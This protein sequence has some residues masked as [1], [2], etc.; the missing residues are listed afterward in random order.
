M[1]KQKDVS[2]PSTNLRPR[3]DPMSQLCGNGRGIG[4]PPPAKFRSGH[5]PATAIPVSRTIPGDDSASGSENDMSTDSEEDVYGGRYSLDS[6]PQRPNGTAYRYGNPS[7]RDSQSHYS[8]DY[9]YSDVGSSMETVAGLTKHLMAMQRRAAEAGNGRYP[10]AQNGFTEDESYDSAASSE[11]STTQVGGSI[12]GGAARR[13]R[14][15]EGY[16][17][18]IPS[19]I[20]V[21]SATE[22]V[23]FFYL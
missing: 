11:F 6:S 21:E 17:S 22:K 13:N 2:I 19:T 23:L 4:L 15:S 7:K 18:S 5:L 12:N 8:S 1:M 9:T 3:I 14:F 20:N 16:A 10:V